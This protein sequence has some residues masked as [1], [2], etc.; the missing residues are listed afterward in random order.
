M[1]NVDRGI[2]SA[3]AFGGAE[4]L[5]WVKL[6]RWVWST[7]G[8][9]THSTADLRPTS[10]PCQKQPFGSLSGLIGTAL[11]TSSQR[12]QNPVAHGITR[13]TDP[14]GGKWR[15][16]HRSRRSFERISANREAV[17]CRAILG[18]RHPDTITRRGGP[19]QGLGPAPLRT[20]QPIR[21]RQCH[22]ADPASRPS[23]LAGS[24][25]R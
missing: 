7:K 23:I 24:D 22:R 11:P 4:G 15:F 18:H 14:C 20:R 8:L 13:T 19:M 25:C 3:A 2:R 12:D 9:L 21:D 10:A 1:L 5:H 17:R 6:S 16:V